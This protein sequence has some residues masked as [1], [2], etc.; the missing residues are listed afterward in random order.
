VTFERSLDAALACLRAGEYDDAVVA[1]DAAAGFAST[2]AEESLVA[3]HRASMDVLQGKREADIRPFLE[4]VVRRHSPRHVQ[5]ATYYILVHAIETN[6]RKL[7]DR[8]FPAYLDAVETVGDPVQRVASYD[9]AAAVES[10]RG[11]HV[12]AIEYGRVALAECDRCNDPDELLSRTFITHNLA[13]NCLAANRFTEALEYA[14][15]AVGHAEK[16]GRADALRQ[17]LITAAFAHL[18]KEQ[19]DEAAALARRAEPFALGT[20]MERYVHYLHGEI[21]RRREDLDAAARHFR[22][23]E[24]F[25]PDTPGVAEILLTLNVA[26][27]LLPE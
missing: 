4:N 3:L 17:L 13:Y 5:I 12:A 14:S 8:Y 10:M 1:L 20:R 22:K 15:A 7:A 23:L 24:E 11:N 2:E 27:F 6:D 26:P 9:V 18:C 19:L 16:L 21:A 25:Y